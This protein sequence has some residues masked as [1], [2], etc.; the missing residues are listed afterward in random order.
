MA[1]AA[2]PAPAR[3]NA[4]GEAALK[5]EFGKA[6]D[7]VRLRASLQADLV[8]HFAGRG[9]GLTDVKDMLLI[10]KNFPDRSERIWVRLLKDDIGVAAES[11]VEC[12]LLWLHSRQLGSTAAVGHANDQVKRALDVLDSHGYT[13]SPDMRQDMES[14]LALG[15]AGSEKEQCCNA[16]A[17]HILYLGRAPESVEEVW[18]LS[19]IHISE[20]TRPY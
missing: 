15:E 14:A 5:A 18:W 9:L 1:A 7:G 2:A 6:Y 10:S 17:V 3:L 16:L 4:A 8:A 13:I 12:F 11:E 19:L 20:P